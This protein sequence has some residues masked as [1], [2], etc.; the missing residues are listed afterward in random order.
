[1]PCLNGVPRRVCARVRACVRRVR[2][3]VRAC[4]LPSYTHTYVHACENAVVWC[5]VPCAC[6]RACLRD[7]KLYTYLTFQTFEIFQQ[8]DVHIKLVPVGKSYPQSV[9]PRVQGNRSS[10]AW[11]ALSLYNHSTSRSRQSSWPC[12]V[13]MCVTK[14]GVPKG[15]YHA[16]PRDRC[17]RPWGC[18]YN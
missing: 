12:D 13:T 7:A 18:R 2:A 17:Q 3:C 15:M 10:G 6:V 16:M 14:R 4:V 8:L 1:M 9:Q 11:A 5:A